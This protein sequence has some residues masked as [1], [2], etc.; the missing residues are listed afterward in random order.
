MI[1][2]VLSLALSLPPSASPFAP[3]PPDGDA[4]WPLR[5]AEREALRALAAL[6][7]AEP[8]IAE[9]QKAAARAAERAV[10]EARGFARRARLGALLP[11]VT[12]EIRRE[13][14]SSRVV[15]LQGSGEVD[16]LRLAP[17]TS[18]AF[19]ATW[20]LGALVAAP[21]EIQAEA[22]A[23]ER[24]KRSAEAVRRSTALFYERRRAQAALL[25]APPDDALERAE[26]E[27][28]VERLGAEL[29]AL[30][31]GLLSGRPR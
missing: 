21:G 19:R 30:T 24:A 3:R 17:A 2:L 4:S 22:A 10:G 14:H 13:D 9:V 16:Y 23:R 26:A 6:E 5:A 20:D 11:R 1:A 18:W 29:D 7:G 12:A 8:G 27:L 31:D 28:E 15:G 25:L